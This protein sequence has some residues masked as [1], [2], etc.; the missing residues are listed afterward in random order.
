MKSEEKYVSENGMVYKLGENDCYYP[1]L[2]CEQGTSYVI[3]KYGSIIAE[4]ICENQRYKYIH[5]LMNGEWNSYLH[6]CEKEC[7]RME[8]LLVEQIKQQ[9][10]VTEQLKMQ[11]QLEWVRRMNEIQLRV[12]AM[13]VREMME[14]SEKW[15][16]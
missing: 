13:V 2:K 1:N 7:Q 16:N 3:G 12:E 6:N 9:E 10:G 15:R 8:D 5:L 4:H 14:G 11:N